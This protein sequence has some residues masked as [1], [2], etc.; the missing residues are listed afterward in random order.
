MD[1]RPILVCL[2]LAVGLCLTAA[3]RYVGGDISLLPKYE[4]A[5]AVY[6]DFE[7]RPIGDLLPFLKTQ[8]MNAMRVR[9]FVN[10]SDYKGADADPNACQ[11]MDYILPL[12]RRIKESGMSL[13]LDFHYSDTWAD[14][15]KQWIPASWS[16]LDETGLCEKI[17]EYTR[18]S[19]MVLDENGVTPDFIQVGN[20]ISYGMLWGPYGTPESDLKKLSWV[21]M[22]TGT[23]SANCLI[24]P[25]RHAGRS[26]RK[27]RL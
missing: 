26:V 25:S 3:E 9:L 23:G 22:Q 10:P 19:L 16:G 13:M 7:S 15:A 27:L 2:A 6:K 12:C 24:T 4:E 1:L 17:Y 14:P 20:E 21:M 11:D 18:E 5:G 8:G